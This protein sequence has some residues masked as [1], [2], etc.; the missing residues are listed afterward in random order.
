MRK[1][2]T[3]SVA[4]LGLIALSACQQIPTAPEEGDTIEGRDR[5]FTSETWGFSITPPP[6]SLWSLSATEFRA[7]REPNG[8]SPVQVIMRRT[9]I[10]NGGIARPVFLMDSYGASEAQELGAVTDAFDAQFGSRFVNYNT[11]GGRDTTTVGGLPAIE[12]RFRARQPESGLHLGHSRF[13]AIVF[14]R[15]DQMYTVLCS[16]ENQDFPELGFRTI[17]S[18]IRFD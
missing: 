13:L 18:S 12:W 15:G 16:G 17:L 10:G 1:T 11:F 8:L 3:W 5:T 14:I 6:D 9:T 7:L 4:L 2:Y